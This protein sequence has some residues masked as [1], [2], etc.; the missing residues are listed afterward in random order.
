MQYE[1]EVNGR[2]RHLDVQRTDDR[3]MV[4]LDGAEWLIDAA[5]VDPHTLSLLIEGRDAAVA[6]HEVTLADDAASGRTAVAVGA[7]PVLVTLNGRRRSRRQGEGSRA[8]GGPQRLLAPMPGKVL[9]LL[10]TIGQ[11]VAERQ[12]LVVVEA[13]KME[14]ELRAAAGG[15]VAELHVHEG[16]SVD[17]GTLLV[18]LAPA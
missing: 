13:M 2:V 6:S 11:A 3:F 5:R 15:V 9:R 8:S 12:P 16:Q 1:V 4:S 18:V 14:N 17:A 10:V 7:V